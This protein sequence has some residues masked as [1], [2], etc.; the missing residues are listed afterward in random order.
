VE[1]PA[2]AAAAEAARDVEHLIPHHE[3][4]STIIQPPYRSTKGWII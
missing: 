1:K 3:T 4:F 2:A